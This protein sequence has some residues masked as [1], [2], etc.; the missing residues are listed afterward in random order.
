M[1][2]PIFVAILALVGLAGTL[3]VAYAGWDEWRHPDQ[4]AGWNRR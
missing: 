3:L 4:Y 1:D 2:A